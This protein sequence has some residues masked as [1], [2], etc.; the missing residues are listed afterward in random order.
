M[1]KILL[2]VLTGISAIYIYSN[3]ETAISSNIPATCASL[4]THTETGDTLR[5]MSFNIWGGGGNSLARTVAVVRE[6]RADIVGIQEESNNAAAHIAKSL[7]WRTVHT[8]V[9]I[10]GKSCA[11]ISKYP[12][13]DT[14]ESKIGIKLQIGDNKYVWMFNQHLNH[15]PYEPYR[16]NGIEYCGGTLYTEEEAVASAWNARKSDVELTIAEIKKTQAEQ[17][18]VFLTGDFNEPSHLDWTERAATAGLCK[19]PVAWPSTKKLQE[20]TG[21]KD[22][23]RI[24]HPNEVSHPGYTWTSM[25]AEKEVLDRIDFV[26]FWGDRVNAVKSEIAGEKM[27]ESDIV[28]QDYPSDHRAVMS[29]FKID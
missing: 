10:L 29:T 16:L 25:P 22:S 13:V 21:M 20:Q 28:I 14:A 7:G 23:Y 27:P 26:F 4:D 18:P 8:Y 1:K 12:A 17:T 6:S 11:I 19:M 24:L 9:S 3:R 2:T 5:I 15:C